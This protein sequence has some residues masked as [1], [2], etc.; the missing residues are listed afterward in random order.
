MLGGLKLLDRHHIDILVRELEAGAYG[1]ARARTRN[2]E[3]PQADAVLLEAFTDVAPWF[4]RSR[5]TADLRRKLDT[6]IRS[7][8]DALRQPNG[9]KPPVETPVSDAMH[10]TIVDLV[11]EHQSVEPLR[12]RKA[13][14]GTVGV[15]AILV[16]VSAFIWL[17]LDALA[18]ARPTLTTMGPS[19]NATAVPIEGSVI[20]TF[21]R[22][23]SAKPSI[24][25]QPADGSL[26]A[27]T[28]DG[29]TL[30]VDY[31]GLRFSKRYTIVVAADYHSRY[32]DVGHF[33][34][35]WSFTTEGYPVLQSL[36]P[37]DG[38]TLV[39]RNGHIAIEFNHRPPL[40]PRVSLVPNADLVA[41]QWSSSTWVVGYSNLAPRT[42]Y[43]ATVDVD[44]GLPSAN[45]HRSWSF[46]TE[47]GAP[48]AGTPVIWSARESPINKVNGPV[49]LAALDWDGHLVG[50]AYVGGAV[51]QAPDGAVMVTDLNGYVAASGVSIAS[52]ASPYP[53]VF[54]DDG[55]S[56]CELQTL[57][58][59]LPGPLWVFTGPLPGPLHPVALAGEF[60]A[61][62]GFGISACSVLNDRVVLD[63]SDVTGTTSV[64]VFT[65][66]SGRLV[67][68]RSYSPSLVS[69][70]SSR[71][72]RFVAEQTVRYDNQAQRS[73][74]D[75]FIRRTTDGAIVAH[76]LNERVVQFSWDDR[77]LVTTSL[78]GPESPNEIDFLDWQSG[79]VLWR[80]PVPMGITGTPIY[81]M[82][83]PRGS[84]MVVAYGTHP[85]GVT[86]QLWILQADG[87]ANQ[88]LNDIFFVLFRPFF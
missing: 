79:R 84:R 28:W 27:S 58:R 51:T 56:I 82:A 33:E 19:A 25:L 5:D 66:S 81:A 83:E 40:E 67:Y 65:L 2:A 10:T 88:V 15:A 45:I 9:S 78:D 36:G 53:T 26:G 77:R 3:S 8:T 80:Q 60:G 22:A 29:K 44:Y 37:A 54:A 46:T 34:Q 47:P 13:I 39:F 42:L 11:E 63:Y 87:T 57:S 61:R 62:S 49:R 69:L 24:I 48:P 68:Q 74:G 1:L 35:R 71:D 64:K 14:L 55:R 21:G 20:L 72:G 70:L 73:I 38:D 4:P 7:R 59:A 6:R 75:A 12:R 85:D 30:T 31:L 43:V 52:S 86:D 18:A 76:L 23:P 17:R 50:T 16:A 41:G 32:R